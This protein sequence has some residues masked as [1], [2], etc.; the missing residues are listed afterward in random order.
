MRELHAG[1]FAAAQNARDR[2]PDG[3]EP[4]QRNAGTF[5]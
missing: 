3:T 5:G 2:L 1:H 4:E